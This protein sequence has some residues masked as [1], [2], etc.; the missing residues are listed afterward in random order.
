[1]TLVHRSGFTSVDEILDVL[2][3]E[4]EDAFRKLMSA[5]LARADDIG[6]WDQATVAIEGY[7][8]ATQGWR[9]E[10]RQQIQRIIDSVQQRDRT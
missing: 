7:R 8:D 4:R 1:M 9:E 3:Q 2:E 5:L 10:A 6:D